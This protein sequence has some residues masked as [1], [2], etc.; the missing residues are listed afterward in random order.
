MALKKMG[1]GSL[2]ASSPTREM[3][4]KLVSP[5]HLLGSVFPHT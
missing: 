1:D 3:A 2:K 5:G 4:H